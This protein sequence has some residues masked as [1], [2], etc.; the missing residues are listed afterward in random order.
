MIILKAKIPQ[1]EFLEV[2]NYALTLP[3]RD[4]VP[5]GAEIV[6][7]AWIELRASKESERSTYT[8]WS[9]QERRP[10]KEEWLEGCALMRKALMEVEERAATKSA[11]K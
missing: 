2:H 3:R 5:F 6:A 9:Q 7:R 10:T 11:R 4:D 1:S 8:D